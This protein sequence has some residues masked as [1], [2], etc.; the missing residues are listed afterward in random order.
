[1]LTQICQDEVKKGR[2][3]V[4]KMI[5]GERIYLPP[6]VDTWLYL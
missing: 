2:M 1:M 5:H 4:R 3:T 6:D